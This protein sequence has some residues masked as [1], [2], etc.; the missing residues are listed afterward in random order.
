[1]GLRAI[2]ADKLPMSPLV[3]LHIYSAEMRSEVM[4]P[5]AHYLGHQTT[6]KDVAEMEEKDGLQRMTSKRWRV[7]IPSL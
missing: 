3:E 4:L 2:P 1:M 5:L 7:P 6:S